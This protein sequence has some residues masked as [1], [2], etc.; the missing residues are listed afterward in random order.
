MYEVYF[1]IFV[2][3]IIPWSFRLSLIWRIIFSD[4]I[5]YGIFF[6]FNLLK[7]IFAYFEELLFV[8]IHISS[9]SALD[10]SAWSISL[11]P[12]SKIFFSIRRIFFWCKDLSCF[13]LLE[14]ND[15]NVLIMLIPLISVHDQT[16][17]HQ[18]ELLN[19]KVVFLVWM[20]YRNNQFSSQYF[21]L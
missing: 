8:E 18:E 6:S 17:L 10:I 16:P 13:T 4:I 7:I 14:D 9:I 20:I 1:G 5:L 21:F 19:L 12:S 3:A 15:I 2:I 11:Y